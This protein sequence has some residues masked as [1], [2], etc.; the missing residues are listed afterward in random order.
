MET[1]QPEKIKQ[2]NEASTEISNITGNEYRGE[3]NLYPILR[4]TLII[5]C[6]LIVLGITAFLIYQN[7][8]SIYDKGL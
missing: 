4:T 6:V 1:T 3:V 5:L 2:N 8:K 7:G